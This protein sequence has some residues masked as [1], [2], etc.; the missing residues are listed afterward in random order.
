MT[1]AVQSLIATTMQAE[2]ETFLAQLEACPAE[3][4]SAQPT[5]GHSAAWH[6]LHIMDWTRCMIQPGLNGVNPSL[7]YGYLGFEQAPWAL[8]VYGPTLAHEQDG[9]EKILGALDN[10]FLESLNAVRTAPAKRFTTSA[11]WTTLKQPK[12]VLD[13]LMY[14]IRH[15]AYHRGQVR[16]VDCSSAIN[17]R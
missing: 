4:F 11:L 17:R 10:T 1:N 6:A 3:M 8:A 16:L 13:G 15:V 14:H 12:S 5:Q 2:F 9:K 7:T